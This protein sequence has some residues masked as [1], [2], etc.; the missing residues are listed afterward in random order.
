MAQQNINIGSAP[1]DGTGDD[2]RTAFD[3]ANDNFAELYSFKNDFSELGLALATAEDG[4][5]VRSA[6][7][8]GSLG[9]QDSDA[10]N[11]TGG[12]LAG[13]TS[14]SLDLSGDAFFANQY[15]NTA[16]QGANLLGRRARGTASSPTNVLSGNALAGVY[17]AGWR[18]TGVWSGFTGSFRLVAAEDFIGTANGTQ[19]EIATTP[20]GGSSRV[21]RFTISPAG[22]LYGNATPAPSMTAGFLYIP[23]GAG[24]PTGIP[25]AVGTNQVPMYYDRTNNQLYVYNGSWKKIGLS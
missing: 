22:S 3:K 7:G 9:A 18:D 20:L 17:A 24:A 19:A 10:V 6:I 16:S 14:L 12:T 21:T 2:L 25:E 15:S 11:I 8:V 5:E 23:G 4:E 1:D 13:L